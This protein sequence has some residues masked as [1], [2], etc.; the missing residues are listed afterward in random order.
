MLLPCFLSILTPILRSEIVT[1]PSK[2][3]VTI[4]RG[5]TVSWGILEASTSLYM[6][7]IKANW[8]SPFKHRSN[9]I[10]FAVSSSFR[11]E[12]LVTTLEFHFTSSLSFMV[13]ICHKPVSSRLWLP[14]ENILTYIPESSDHIIACLEHL[15]DTQW[16]NVPVICA[17]K[18]PNNSHSLAEAPWDSRW[19]PL[20][21]AILQ[22]SK[23]GKRKDGRC[24]VERRMSWL[25]LCFKAFHIEL[26]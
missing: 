11:Q 12:A 16:E 23:T 7:W 17:P 20:T 22:Y 24:M 6:Y 26:R 4:L 10:S 5:T 19:F 15:I 2:E 3:L 21:K 18:L 13:I 9:V 1:G 14:G 25:S 8:S